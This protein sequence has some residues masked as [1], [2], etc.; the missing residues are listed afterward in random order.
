M[1]AVK[2]TID[3]T[4]ISAMAGVTVLDAARDAE[5]YIPSI[6]S[7]PDLEC[8]D[9]IKG[10][11]MVFRGGDRIE[12]DDPDA[13]WD[14][15]GLCVVE[16]DGEIVR[17]CATEVVDGMVVTT[18]CEGVLAER[19]RKL[20]RL[21]ADH[22]HTCL[23][24]A[25][26]EGCSI[27]QCSTNVP[28]DERCCELLG[29]CELQ[30]VSQ[31][32]GVPQ[33]V[34]KYKPRGLPALED[35]PLFDHKTELCIG[36]LRCV[37]AC[38]DLRDVGTLSFVIKDG[39]PV[40]GT[41]DGPT[42][43]ES[44]CR[45]CG[46]CIEVCPTGALMDKERAVGGEREKK[47]VPCR[48]SCP[49]GVDIPR[50]IRH[51]ARGETGKAI[52]VIREKLPLA[53]APSYVCFHPCEEVCHRGQVTSAVSVCRLKRFAVDSDTGEW[54]SGVTRKP[55]TAKKVAV[56]GSGPAGLTAAYY[57][58][59]QGHAVTVF[60]ELKEAG[61]MLRVGIPEYRF[62]RELL[63]KDLEEVRGMGVE[64]ECDSKVDRTKLDR[65]VS[66][67]DA[68]FVAAGAHVSKRIELHGS[69][70]D[71]VC[72]GMDFLRDRSLGKIEAGAFDCKRV[73]VVGGG[74]VAVD[75]AR[76]ARRLGSDDVTMVS[77]E[78][79]EE[80]P[81]HDWEIEEAR[82]EGIK[83]VTGWGPAR[84]DSQNS[85]VTGLTVKRCTRVFDEKGCFSPAYDEGETK[86]LAADIVI[87]AIGQEASSGPFEICGLSRERTIEADEDTLA[88]RVAKVY[89][90]GDVVAGPGSV[91]EAIAMGRKAAIEIDRALGG[92]GD[93]EVVLT[94]REPVEHRLGKVENFAALDCIR[95]ATLDAGSR[96]G[97]F[98]SIERT[99]TAD[100]ARS[101]AARCLNCHLRLEITGITL[102]PRVEL[103]FELTPESVESAPETEGVFQLYD[104]EK[105]VISITGV[106]NLKESLTEVLE[107]NDTA[108]FF[109]LEQDPMYTKRESELIQQY[110]K[111]HG[112]L[113]GGGEDDLDDLF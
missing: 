78:S 16:I 93:I 13:T 57:L 109:T 100:E 88:T 19:G 105:K 15:C 89:A 52:A 25:Q 9:R 11:S 90:G 102:P 85:K 54:R 44:H 1:T 43:K 29:S 92:D 74:N 40:V 106:M 18:N 4:E 64:I 111:E 14:G 23:T 112:E 63:E 66:D 77:L 101:E 62:P 68:V 6:C 17:S 75:A 41:L 53:F 99:L 73:V 84:V 72:W 50:F 36:C 86:E 24:C 107:E 69:D 97:S 113:P 51:I 71:G 10:D 61:G 108:R 98:A 59:C 103:L 46:A 76:V 20:A 48:S 45:F 8:V 32:I 82:E 104:A 3:G 34:P 58:A 49:A 67:C 7:H 55:S 95:P 30:R 5:I 94:D 56:V 39:K 26:A 70:L 2:L 38:R 60:E 110:L 37:R 80:L 22:P 81:A 28:E 65:L 27:T 21:L 79:P 31:F 33:D 42:R 87:L 12:T 96:T 91:I 35:E 47:L 83:L